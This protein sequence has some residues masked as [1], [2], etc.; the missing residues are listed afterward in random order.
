M[1]IG[2]I[3]AMNEEI[4]LLL[5]ALTDK[6]EIKGAG[7]TYYTGTLYGK[8]VVICKSGVGKVNAAVT[9]QV[10]IDRFKVEK[11]LFT[12]VAGAVDPELQI[13]DIV[14]SSACLQHDMDVTPLGFKPGEI[15]YQEQSVFQADQDLVSLAEKVC[16]ARF[17]G[18]YRTGL[19]LSG[20]Q[21]IASREKVRELHETF[22]GFCTEM[23][24]S[25]VAQT[26]AL[27]DIP[28]VIIRSMSDR[29]D[30]SAHMNFAEF[31]VMASE[32]SHLIIQDMLNQL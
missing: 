14:I 1:T 25:A 3:G 16:E 17:P 8:S 23:E 20:D 18:R 26:C 27:N 6:A 22:Q 31:T 30:G 12:G 5:E 10:M 19:V 21:F 2:I 28:F 32:H 4:Q 11:V 13:G 7:T 9:T 29:A 24:G 15:P